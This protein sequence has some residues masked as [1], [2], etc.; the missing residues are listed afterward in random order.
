MSDT[1]ANAP[2]APATPTTTPPADAWGQPIT[3]AR[4]AELDALAKRQRAWADQP[5]A[6]RSDSPCKGV[7]LTGADVFWL[8]ARALTGPT[9]DTAS[10]E[11]LL[12]SA[13]PVER[14]SV[15]V[16]A[17]HLAGGFVVCFVVSARERQRT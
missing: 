2:Q 4:K 9:G 1:P 10:F 7:A 8:A 15:D 13:D 11:A 3:D 14:F 17:L 12:R 6:G 16:S 5:P